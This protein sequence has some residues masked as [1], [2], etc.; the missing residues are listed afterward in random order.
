MIS[1]H[2]VPVQIISL[3]EAIYTLENEDGELD[4]VPVG[5]N[6]IPSN[7]REGCPGFWSNSAVYLA[8]T[9]NSALG[10][11]GGG[12]AAT[13]HQEAHQAVKVKKEVRDAVAGLSRPLTPFL[14]PSHLS[15]PTTAV[16]PAH[17]HISRGLHISRAPRMYPALYG[18][19]RTYTAPKP[20]RHR[21]LSCKLTL[22]GDRMY[23]ARL[24]C[25]LHLLVYPALPY[26]FHL[27]CRP[28]QNR[29]CPRPLLV[30]PGREERVHQRSA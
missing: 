20:S 22:S 14:R 25:I 21:R 2:L 7:L 6:P 23:P 13:A 24:A 11:S 1:H 18:L 5:R 30:P 15:R 16:Y 27:S 3:S 17:S 29:R 10:A 12:K 4:P 28:W 9:A 26:F 8:Q 19:S